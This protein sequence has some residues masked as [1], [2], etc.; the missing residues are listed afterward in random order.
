MA[1]LQE[2]ASVWFCIQSE[3]YR[4]RKFVSKDDINKMHSHTQTQDSLELWGRKAGN[5]RGWRDK[6]IAQV[7]QNSGLL[8]ART[9]FCVRRTT[10]SRTR[11]HDRHKIFASIGQIQFDNKQEITS[12]YIGERFSR[13]R[14]GLIFKTRIY[15][16]ED[17]RSIDW[18]VFEDR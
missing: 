18:K 6:V 13:D 2:Q 5:A 4:G 9:C 3:A 10:A 1:R 17:F 14:Q 11:K 7:K 16:G 8:R 15:S 12:N